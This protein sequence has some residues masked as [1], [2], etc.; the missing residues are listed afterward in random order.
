MLRPMDWSP[1]LRLVAK[2]CWLAFLVAV[3]VVFSKD[4]HDFVYRAF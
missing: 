2:I 4:E 1:R 3:L